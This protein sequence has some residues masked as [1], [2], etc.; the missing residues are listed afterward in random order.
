MWSHQPDTG[1]T[2]QFK[3]QPLDPVTLNT[4]D[5]CKTSSTEKMPVSSASLTSNRPLRRI[6]AGVCVWQN[7]RKYSKG[8]LSEQAA[9]EAILLRGKAFKCFKPFMCLS[10]HGWGAPW[11]LIHVSLAP[12]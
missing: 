1:C 9:L 3:W 6:D 2:L 7:M 5:V 8:L 12:I 4:E 10:L 11:R